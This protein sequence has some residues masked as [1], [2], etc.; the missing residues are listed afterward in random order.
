MR[1]LVTGSTGFI[2]QH[3]VRHLAEEGYE[4]WAAARDA[5]KAAALKADKV[6]ICDIRMRRQVDAMV[7]ASQPDVIYHLAAQSYPTKSWEDPKLT[8][9]TN[10]VGTANLFEAV[11]KAGLDPLV[12]VACS[13][14]EYGFVREAEVPVKENHSL[15]PLHP[16]GVSKVAQDLLTYQYFKNNGLRGVR[17]RIFNTTGP[18][19]K[20]DVVSDFAMRIAECERGAGNRIVHGN[21]A[22]RRD[23]TDVRDM[24][25]AL[26]SCERA[27]PGEAYNLCSM[28]AHPISGLLDKLIKM[29]AKPIALEQDPKLMRPTDEPVIMGDNT[30]FRRKTGWKPQIRIEKT[31]QD[32]LNHWRKA[33]G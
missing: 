13:S 5:G 24:V 29:A 3:L 8:L 25:R 7:D 20:K 6:A 2:G 22:A 27:Q 14:A 1:A 17:A 9:E 21:L 32:T 4:V 18:G 23:I 15:Q 30:K 12:V 28:R 10:A 19:K 26:H 16:Y 11:L 33:T 31:L